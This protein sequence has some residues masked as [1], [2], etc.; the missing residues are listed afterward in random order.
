MKR[1]A[2]P[3]ELVQRVEWERLVS[4]R[5]RGRQPKRVIL[6]DEPSDLPWDEAVSRFARA[7]DIIMRMARRLDSKR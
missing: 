6:I 1:I 7:N 5:R 2:V 3:T 4:I